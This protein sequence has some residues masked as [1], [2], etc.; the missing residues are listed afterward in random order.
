M[1]N[2]RDELV[3]IIIEIGMVSGEGKEAWRGKTGFR[4]VK[5]VFSTQSGFFATK[6]SG[7]CYK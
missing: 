2:A 3:V 1:E 6:V 5:R 7:S 4:P